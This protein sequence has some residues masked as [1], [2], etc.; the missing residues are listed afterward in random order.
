MTNQAE[1]LAFQLYRR[2]RGGQ[3][4]E[5]LASELAIP[6][7]RIRLRIKAAAA[8]WQRTAQADPAAGCRASLISLCEKLGEAA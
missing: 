5:Q 3:S 4:F 1:P 2:F 6:I 7:D 8:Y